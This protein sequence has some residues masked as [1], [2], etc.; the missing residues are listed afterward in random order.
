MILV[1]GSEGFIGRNLVK[2]LKDDGNK[3]LEFDTKN[4]LINDVF[5]MY[6][7]SEIERIYH[8]GAIS[9]TVEQDLSLLYQHNVIFS[10]DLFNYAIIHRIPVVYASS[11]SVF[12]NTI[13]DEQYI[14]NPLT[15]Y[16]TT[17]MLTEMW[18]ADNYEKFEDFAVLRF[19]NVYGE[20]ERK[21]DMT[22]SP[23]YRF[24]QQALN[25]GYIKL[26]RES[27]NMIRDF[28]CVEDVI[29]AMLHVSQRQSKKFIDI[30]TGN[31]ISFQQ[32]AEMCSDKY[33]VPIKYVNM[34]LSMKGKYQYY[35]RAR[36]GHIPFFYTS[37]GTWL[38]NHS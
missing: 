33:N 5:T 21:D 23:I 17:K 20:D 34:P 2:K 16:A 36:P 9:S 8:L 30:G 6:E 26:F 1:T 27:H 32:V 22:T 35:T 31:P 13:K 7:F 11:A 18:I 14:Y 24:K 29:D 10:I 28:V 3:V 15:Y 12:G 37:V 4:H 38:H 25:D 19:F